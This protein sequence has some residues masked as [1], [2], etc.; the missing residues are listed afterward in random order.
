MDRWEVQSTQSNSR[1]AGEGVLQRCETREQSID[2]V[3]KCSEFWI[4]EQ[5]RLGTAYKEYEELWPGININSSSNSSSISSDS[6][7]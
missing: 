6:M 1:A 5:L 2:V 4:S 7:R 3:P